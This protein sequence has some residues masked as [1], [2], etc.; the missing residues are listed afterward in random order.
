MDV[1]YLAFANQQQ[2][3]LPTLQEEDQTLYKL[4]STRAKLQH[5]QLHRD[6]FVSLD[7]LPAFLTLYRDTV[8]IFLFSGHAGRDR[9]ILAENQPAYASGIAAMLGQ[10]PNLKLVFLN[11]CSTQGQVAQ[12]LAHQVPVVIATSAPVSDQSATF[13][14]IRFFE[15]LDQQFSIRE[16]FEM[17]KA[18]TQAKFSGIDPVVRDDLGFSEYQPEAPLWGLFYSPQTAHVTEWKLP[19]KPTPPTDFGKSFTPNQNLIDVLFKALSPYNEEIRKMARQAASGVNAPLPKK[20]MAVLNAL[21][22]PLAEPL[23]KLLVPVEEENEGYDKIGESRLRQIAQAFNITLELLV[24]TMLAQLWAAFD[25][26]EGLQITDL[27]RNALRGFFRMSKAEKELYDPIVIVNVI[28]EIFDQNRISYFV[29]ELENLNAHLRTDEEFAH[30]LQLLTGLRIQLRQNN[31]DRSALGML[32]QRAEEALATL[33][34]QMGFLASYRL[35]TIQGIDVEK[36]RHRRQPT[37]NHATVMLHDLLGGFEVSE[38]HLSQ[39]LDN[40]SILLLNEDSWQFLNLSPFVI[41]ENAFQERTEIC[42][43]YFFSHWSRAAK[44]IFFKYVNKPEDPLL[45]VSESELPLVWE[46]F[47]V[48]SGAILQTQLD[49]L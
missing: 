23:R 12:L 20:R 39:F 11:G 45:E 34:A 2:E 18:A 42:K 9:L 48:F 6:S 40:R 33:Y 29:Q 5:F 38:V 15:A 27:Q 24:N 3:L 16:A 41:D 36:Y 43:L 47:Q 46:Q 25:S 19:A 1:L 44:K 22:A 7:T 37:F 13:F 8:R 26:N 21:P 14:S 30:T 17:A 28:K 35:A 10:C 4:L 31:L 49:D 32:N